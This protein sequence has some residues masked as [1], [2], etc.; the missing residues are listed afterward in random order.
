MSRSTTSPPPERSVVS[1]GHWRA[2]EGGED[3]R[4]AIRP[5]HVCQP[6]SLGAGTAPKSMTPTYAAVPP[7]RAQLAVKPSG[8]ALRC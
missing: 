4:Q 8:G 7:P 5:R 6:L 3:E 1:G 2:S